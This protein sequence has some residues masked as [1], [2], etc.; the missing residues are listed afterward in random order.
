[1]VAAR[2]EEMEEFRKHGVYIKVPIKECMERTGKK[3]IGVRWVDINKG[4]HVSPEYRSRLVAKEIKMDKRSDLFAATPPIEAL[5]ML[6]SA[7][8][9]EGNGYKKGEQGTGNENIIYRCTK[10]VFPGRRD[11]RGICRIT[12]G[13]L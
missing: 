4:D 10:G 9:T 2:I 13:G 6:L 1:M 8:V 7:A 3:P 5:K 12:R 11:Q